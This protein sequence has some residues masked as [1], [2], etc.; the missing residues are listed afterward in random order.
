MS[1]F[2]QTL[3]LWRW[4]RGF[5]Q[6]TLAQRAGLARPSLSA[7]ERGQR[8]VTLATLRALAAAL[9]V[10]PGVLADGVVPG[11][12]QGTA[13][14]FSRW[15]LE[16]IADGVWC[17]TALSDS[18]ERAIAAALRRVVGLLLM[19]K[20]G[21]RG[22]SQRQPRK[23]RLAWLWLNAAY[24]PEV[25]RSLVQRVKERGWGGSIKK[26]QELLAGSHG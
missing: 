16:R 23:A 21:R 9:D 12:R 14:P 18:E 8:E 25:V 6:D 20:R 24:P 2:N 7:I 17:E 19:A 5:T 11:T 13:Q 1:P 3:L 15:R 10:R 4:Y 22:G 26:F